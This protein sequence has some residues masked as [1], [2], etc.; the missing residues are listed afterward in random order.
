[1]IFAFGSGGPVLL[2][3]GF[4]FMAIIATAIAV[5]LGELASAYP[6]S[7]MLKVRSLG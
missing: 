2:I 3:Y 1:L 4:L 6:N 7:G 5:S